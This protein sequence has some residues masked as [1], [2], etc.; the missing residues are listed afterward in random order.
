VLTLRRAIMVVVCAA[1]LPAAQAAPFRFVDSTT[2]FTIDPAQT[3][4]TSAQST[5]L[6]EVPGYKSRSFA[7][8]P[9]NDNI[10]RIFVLQPEQLP[11]EIQPE[12]IGRLY[13]DDATVILGFVADSSTGKALAG[14][15]IASDP[16]AEPAWTDKRGFFQ[17]FV[18]CTRERGTVR[19]N[20]PGYQM[21]DQTDVE[22]YPRGDCVCRI[23]LHSE[24][25]PAQRV[26]ASVDIVESQ[27]ISIASAGTNS[28]I[29]RVPLNIR[30]SHTNGIYY[31]TLDNY[32]KHS[33]PREWF[34][35]WANYIGGSNS[36]N[37]GAVAVR[38]YAIGYVNSPLAGTYDICASTSCQVYNPSL[39]D[40]RSDRAVDFTSGCVMVNSNNAIPRGLTEYSAENNQLNMP[41]GDGFTAPTGGCLADPV[42]SGEPENGHGRGMCQWGSIRW[43]SGLKLPGPNHT[44]DGSVTSYPRQ[45][46]VWILNHYYPNL[47]LIQA[48]PLE[49][50]DPVRVIGVSTPLN[51]RACP[52]GTITNGVNCPS[53][54]TRPLGSFGYAIEGPVQVF[55]DG[56][57]YTWWKV[58]WQNGL[59]GWS[60]ENYLDRFVPTNT[61]PQLAAVQDAII[62]AGTTFRLTNSVVDNDF[63]PNAL[64]FSLPVGPAGATINPTNGVLIW[65][66]P[67]AS[68]DTTN[69][70]T[71]RVTD[72]GSPP[73]SNSVSFKV[74]VIPPPR[75]TA[76]IPSPATL[77]L[78]WTSASKSRYRVDYANDLSRP[79]WSSLNGIVTATGPM[80]AVT[81]S[82][83]GVQQRFYRVVVVE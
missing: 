64:T 24:G 42:C 67:V 14:V 73:M 31:E 21:Q 17:I 8:E 45:D 1:L 80:T 68:A 35:S 69:N 82:T 5:F 13:R 47:R 77:R 28:P 18:P 51:V 83:A 7:N 26:E 37:A 50:G 43:A 12:N 34:A 78:A 3:K 72:N 49:L 23:Q 53:V 41:C 52:G 48:A 79:A 62:H 61:A 27:S 36:L 75:L 57:G 33:L 19:F 39:T 30:V 65:P 2:G 70:F 59:E 81:N 46:W 60:V 44:N 29:P 9:F 56:Q 66:S 63:P 11:P 54:G 76:S 58:H 15:Q 25:S 16:T 10:P 74:T 40:T 22:L 6:I 71:V 38:T 4:I 20:K 32:C 55:A